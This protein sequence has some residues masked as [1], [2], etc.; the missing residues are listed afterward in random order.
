MISLAREYQPFVVFAKRA[1]SEL[2]RWLKDWR[3]ALKH[4]ERKREVLLD[5]LANCAMVDSSPFS[6]GA[7]AFMLIGAFDA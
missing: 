6:L 4:I 3:E 5:G 1:L 2:G 7:S